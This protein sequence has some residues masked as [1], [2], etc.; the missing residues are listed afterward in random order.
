MSDRGRS[1]LNVHHL[2]LA[3]RSTRASPLAGAPCLDWNI[4]E[5]SRAVERHLSWNKVPAYTTV[6][7]CPLRP[8]RAKVATG[9]STLLFRRI[10][11]FGG[12]RV[13]WGT[14]LERLSCPDTLLGTRCPWKNPLYKTKHLDIKSLAQM[15][16]PNPEHMK[17]VSSY[18][19]RYRLP[20][21][22]WTSL[23]DVVLL[24]IVCGML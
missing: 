7:T 5:S 16:G 3:L 22:C 18:M 10:L 13:S 19:P 21:G 6:Q 17:G 9:S 20:S 15:L 1:Y 11:R 8:Y 14:A 12:S 23:I 2:T 4:Q 24:V